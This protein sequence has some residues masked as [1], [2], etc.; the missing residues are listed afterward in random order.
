MYCTKDDMV[1][2][3]G[4]QELIDLTAPGEVQINEV[5]LNQA[6]LYASSLI[7]SYLGGRYQLPLN[8]V[9]TVLTRTA[10]NLTRYYLYNDQMTEAVETSYKGSIK[11][12]SD[13]SK[14]HV[15]LGVSSSGE[16][17]VQSE[18]LSQMTSSAPVW[19]RDRS[20]PF[21]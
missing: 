6:V 21:I 18:S 4:S 1:S 7:D 20:K 10:C 15:R 5:V 13:V 12:L 17:A 16:S 8:P 2:R 19:G 11:F 9:P 14:G 3:F